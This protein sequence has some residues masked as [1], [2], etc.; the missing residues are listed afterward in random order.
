MARLTQENISKFKAGPV[1][2]IAME[3]APD[4]SIP[5][6][7]EPDITDEEIIDEDVDTTDTSTDDDSTT[8]TAGFMGIPTIAWIAIGGVALYFAYKKGMLKKIIK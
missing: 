5:K 8:K 4:K 2:N 6:Y 7:K 1:A 3:R